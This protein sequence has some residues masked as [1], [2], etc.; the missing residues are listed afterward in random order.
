MIDC[1]KAQAERYKGEERTRCV[2]P[3]AITYKECVND[4]ICSACPLRMARPQA[5]VNL[6][7]NMLE[8]T[9]G[10]QLWIENG[11]FVEKTDGEEFLLGDWMECH[12]TSLGITQEKWIEIKSS[13][14]L[15]PTCKCEERKEWLN[16]VGTKFGNA[17]KQRFYKLWY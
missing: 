3:Q 4:E 5:V 12:L 7:V 10:G 14:G 13:V 1:I 16:Q 6:D 17:I 8:P 2:H 15:A 9:H 11:Q